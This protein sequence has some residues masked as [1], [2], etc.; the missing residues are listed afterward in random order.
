[1]RPTKDEYYLNIAREV[2]RRSTCFRTKLGAVIVKN[3]VIVAT[4][5]NGAPRK[6]KDCFEK[7]ECLR[8]KYKIPHGQRYE[9]CASV[10]AEK[11]AVINAARSGVSVLGGDMY[12]WG[13]DRNGQQIDSLPCFICK[14]IIINAGLERLIGATKEGD[15]KTFEVDDWV[16]EWQEKDI[17]DDKHQY[18]TDLNI[19]E[20]LI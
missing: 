1:M 20:N 18:G 7:G 14:K 6:T 8:D 13:E 19:K 10:H 11:N 15:Y 2:A 5:Y 16:R 12:L 3:R 9:V 17:L 4:G